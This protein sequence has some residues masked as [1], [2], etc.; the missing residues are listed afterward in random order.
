MGML[1]V[2]PQH[3]VGEDNGMTILDFIRSI[4]TGPGVLPPSPP[5]PPSPDLA[6]A[7]AAE[8]ARSADLARKLTDLTDRWHSAQ[9]ALTTAQDTLHDARE[10]LRRAEVDADTALTAGRAAREEANTLRRQLA[11]AESA[12][13]DLVAEADAAKSRNEALQTASDALRE[14]VAGL[15]P[16]PPPFNV[17]YVSTPVAVVRA[18]I[19]P[20][21]ANYGFTDKPMPP[22][23]TDA[24]YNLFQPMDIVPFCDYWRANLM[25]PPKD[26][27]SDCDDRAFAFRA[28]FHRWSEYRLPVGAAQVLADWALV[29]GERFPHYIC[30]AVAPD[31]TLWCIDPAFLAQPIPYSKTRVTVLRGVF[32]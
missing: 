22:D 24:N 19:E 23:Y 26:E 18:A 15:P 20:I 1:G 13:A 21:L 31:R 32:Y 16:D 2:S 7:L 4:L 5:A 11:E 25:P 14:R 10:A 29:N 3:A 8:K 27:E 17:A 28:D 9:G 30:V 12:K 6:S